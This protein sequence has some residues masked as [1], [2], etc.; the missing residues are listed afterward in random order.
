METVPIEAINPF[1]FF[2]QAVI[3]FIHIMFVKTSVLQ[4]N[5]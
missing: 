1:L 3:F 4:K 5:A 2:T